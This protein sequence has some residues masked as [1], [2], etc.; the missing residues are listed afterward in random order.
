MKITVKCANLGKEEAFELDNA[1]MTVGHL[2]ATIA[3]RCPTIPA[4][5]QRL[6]F[7]GRILKDFQTLEQCGIVDGATV[8]MVKGAARRPDSA[9]TP[10]A[11]STAAG[12]SAGAS[13]ASGT[14]VPQS[15]IGSSS[16][17][18]AGT[19]SAGVPPMVPP[20]PPMAPAARPD[21]NC[22]SGP[23]N[24]MQPSSFHI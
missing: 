3:E 10:G 2:K 7:A 21:R 19:T 5:Q 15:G 8:H 17:A 13:A 14:G 23:L 20:M 12:A 11:S 16:S 24:T 9:A 18:G 4:E 6:I 22:S 1:G